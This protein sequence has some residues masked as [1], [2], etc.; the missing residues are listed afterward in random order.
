MVDRLK[1]KIAIVFGAGSSGLAWAT[2]DRTGDCPTRNLS[3][4]SSTG[5]RS[6]SGSVDDEGTRLRSSW[7]TF[8]NEHPLRFSRAVDITQPRG[9][10]GCSGFSEAYPALTRK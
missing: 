8:P 3:P 5:S 10:L 9:M 7:R 1:G 4:T 2:R 6:C